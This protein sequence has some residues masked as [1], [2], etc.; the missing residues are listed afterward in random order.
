MNRPLI[1]IENLNVTLNKKPILKNLSFQVFEKKLTSIVGLSGAGKS[2]LINTILKLIPTSSGGIKYASNDLINHVGYVFQDAQLYEEISVYKNLYLSIKNSYHWTYKTLMNRIDAFVQSLKNQDRTKLES[3]VKCLGQLYQQQK[4]SFDLKLQLLK[5]QALVLKYCGP[6]SWWLL[7]QNLNLKSEIEQK[8]QDLSVKLNIDHILKNK[9]NQ[10][11]GGQR[12]RVAIAKSL[13]KDCKIIF[14]DEPF[15]SLDALTKN[16]SRDWIRD[17]QKKY[18]L[19]ILFITHDQNDALLISDYIAIMEK[20][21][22]SQFDPPSNLFDYPRTLKIAQFIGYPE[23]NLM[24]KDDNAQYYL[25][26]KHLQITKGTQ[27]SDYI[28]NKI[29]NTGNFLIY[30]VKNLQTQ[31]SLRCFHNQ[32][33][34]AINDRVDLIY[35]PNNLIKFD[36]KGNN[37]FYA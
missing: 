11:S 21:Q 23:I 16:T 15:S 24:Y 17:I 3:A 12:Q 20:G 8:I 26:P 30:E 6:K 4:S 13:I 25:R 1:T 27:K 31:N 37:L 2:T 32:N 19:T 35:D 5:I 7:H 22:I 9:A 34:I 33:N 29:I 18:E 28:V 14:M 10:I 36:H